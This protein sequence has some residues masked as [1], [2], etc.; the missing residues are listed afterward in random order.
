MADEITVETPVP[1]P[2]ISEVERIAI[3]EQARQQAVREEEQNR[4]IERARQ[5]A[6]EAPTRQEMESLRSY[7]DER[8]AFLQGQQDLLSQSM[9]ALASETIQAVET[10]PEPVEVAEETPPPAVEPKKRKRGYV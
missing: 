4:E 2:G 5:A 10:P 6:M 1:L 9:D 3:E 8:I 7:V